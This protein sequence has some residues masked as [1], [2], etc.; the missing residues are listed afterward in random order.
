MLSVGLALLAYLT[1]ALGPA[2]Y[3]QYATVMAILVWIDWSA[4][5]L[6]S[7]AAT[8]LV[9]SADDPKAVGAALIRRAMLVGVFAMALLWLLATPLGHEMGDPEIGSWLRLAAIEIP[10]FVTAKCYQSVLSGLGYFTQRAIV[11][12]AHW[13]TRL[14]LVLTFVSLGGGVTGALAGV[15]LSTGVET[16]LAWTVCPLPVWRRGGSPHLDRQWVWRELLPHFGSVMAIRATEGSDL[17]LLQ[18]LAPQSKAVAD[19][20]VALQGSIIPGMIGAALFP[21][22]L[23][24]VV[25]YRNQGRPDQIARLGERVVLAILW[26]IPSTLTVALAGSTWAVV[27][28]GQD[29]TTAGPLIGTMLMVGLARLALVLAS[30]LIAGAGRTSTACMVSWIGVPAAL[31]GYGFLI[32]AWDAIG[33]AIATLLGLTVSLIIASSVL[34]IGH[35]VRLPTAGT[36]RV[37]LITTGAVI[38]TLSLPATPAAAVLSLSLVFGVSGATAWFFGDVRLPSNS[39][40]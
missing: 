38:L 13:L 12:G 35:S 22:I 29:Y 20:A 25:R 15:I 33:A 11:V 4:S 3:A 31:L 36:F 2:R 10:L 27:A 14:T 39:E 9:A 23:F 6:L 30:G 5:A 37:G 1:R 19:F 40:P 17:L 7:R 8:K 32:P 28:F 34:A 26:L 16:I 21:S 24:L 18:L